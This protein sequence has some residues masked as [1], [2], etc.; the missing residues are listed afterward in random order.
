M[1]KPSKRRAARSRT[2]R[3]LSL[4]E[5]ADCAA[6]TARQSNAMT[7]GQVARMDAASRHEDMFPNE[8]QEA[9]GADCERAAEKAHLYNVGKREVAR[10]SKGDHRRYEA[11]IDRL[12]RRL[13]Y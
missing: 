3:Q 9:I 1:S 10:K 7:A 8:L 6:P 2:A 5:V 4:E 11:G 13:R 12:L